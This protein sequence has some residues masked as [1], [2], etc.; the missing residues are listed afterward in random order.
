MSFSIKHKNTSA[1]GKVPQPADIERGEIAVNLA[2]KKL[3]TKD[4][5]DTIVELGGGGITIADTAPVGA[6]AGDLWFDS[7]NLRM[8]IRYDDGSTQQWVVTSGTPSGGGTVP[9]ATTTVKGIVQLADQAAW[10]AG[11]AGR[12]VDAPTL[13]T[14]ILSAGTW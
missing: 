9:D 3:F 6:K 12:V 11:T 1:P 8:M 2:D 5:N 10:T 4:V 14:L 7:A 13:K